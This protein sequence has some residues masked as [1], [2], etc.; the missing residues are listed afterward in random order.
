MKVG[1]FHIG[2]QGLS[3]IH[4]LNFRV[5]QIAVKAAKDAMP[6]VEV[7]HLAS[8]EAQELPG[9]D[10]VFRRKKDVPMAMF[11]MQHHASVEGDWL[12]IDT[13]VI[14]K[15]DVRDVF[16]DKT[17][18]IAIADRKGTDMEGSSYAKVMPYNMGVVFSRSPAFWKSAYIYLSKLPAQYQEWEGDQ[19]VV[20]DMIANPNGYEVKIIP[21]K[22]YNYPPQKG[23][24]DQASILHY[25]GARKKWLL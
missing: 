24:N 14:I 1:I 11:R 3:P 15:K 22:T 9:V 2:N 19:R 4:D 17:F 25:K 13:D 12:F 20:C 7:C 5:G 8:S 23:E 10:R 6:D 16:D 21:G 18:D